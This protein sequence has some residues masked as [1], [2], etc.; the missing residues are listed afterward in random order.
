MDKTPTSCN[1][2]TWGTPRGLREQ[3]Q[4][5]LADTREAPIVGEADTRGGGDKP[6]PHSST[7]PSQRPSYHWRKT[8]CYHS[9]LVIPLAHP[10]SGDT[11]P[12]EGGRAL[13]AGRERDERVG[14][15]VRRREHRMAERGARQR[16]ENTRA[17]GKP[18]CGHGPQDLCP[19]TPATKGHCQP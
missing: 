14:N 5:T 6:Q 13:P 2:T 11:D 4:Q 19:A 12:V 7:N 8:H 3:V 17:V 1:T 10:S 16:L 15:D 18:H 9:F